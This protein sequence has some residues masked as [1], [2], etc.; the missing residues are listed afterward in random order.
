MRFSRFASIIPALAAGVTGCAKTVPVDNPQ[1][2]RASRAT[3]ATTTAP[4]WTATLNPVQE[5]TGDLRQTATNRSRGSFT[6]TEGDRPGWSHVSLQFS[7]NSGGAASS[8]VAW[9]ILPGSCGS[10]TAP[11]LP[12][13]AFPL[14]ELGGG[15][16]GT[17]KSQ[18]HV[19]FPRTGSYHVNVYRGGG[20]INRE[21]TS[22][23]GVITCGNMKYQR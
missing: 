1:P 5:R 18:I 16:S 13:S 4:R 8:A 17:V 6:M 15:G 2:D 9:A 12:V 10:D 7:G 11:V 22:I 20:T 19:D 23:A 14:I 21:S 3:V